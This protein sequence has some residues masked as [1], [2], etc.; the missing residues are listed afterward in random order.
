VLLYRFV[1]CWGL[2]PLGWLAVA[3]DPAR[4]GKRGLRLD[5]VDDELGTV[6]A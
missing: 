1:N 5:V 2:I 3:L 6:A 4:R